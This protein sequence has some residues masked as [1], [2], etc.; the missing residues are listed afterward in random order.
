MKRYF[1]VGGKRKANSIKRR[2][3]YAKHRRKQ[4]STYGRY[5]RKF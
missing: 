5:K 2:R 3:D 1:W 4:G